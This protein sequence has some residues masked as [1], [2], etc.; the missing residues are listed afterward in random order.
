MVAQK[1]SL[2]ILNWDIDSLCSAMI[3][4]TDQVAESSKQEY[5]EWKKYRDQ[6]LEQQKRAPT[7]AFAVD[8]RVWEIPNCWALTKQ[9]KQELWYPEPNRYVEQQPRKGS[10]LDLIS[11]FSCRESKRRRKGSELSLSPSASFME[12]MP[13]DDDT[14]DI[15]ENRHVSNLPVMAVLN[16]QQSQREERYCDPAIISKIYRQCSSHSSYAAQMRA[17]HDEL[18][19][20]AYKF[21]DETSH[22]HSLV[23]SLFCLRKR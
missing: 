4:V 5:L 21:S 23:T 16:E 10:S 6:R 3:N 13:Q 18:E 14:A 12:D 19:I 22:K 20:R 17:L 8:V 2:M 11:R 1:N 9:E 15:L 7:V